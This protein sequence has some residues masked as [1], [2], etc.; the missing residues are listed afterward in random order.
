MADHEE[1]QESRLYYVIP[2]DVMI[3]ES[4]SASEKLLYALLSGLASGKGT[5]FPSNEYLEKR[6]K[7]SKATI[8]RWIQNLENAGYI[9]REIKTYADNPFKRTRIITLHVNFKKSLPRLKNEP[10]E[11]EPF[12]ELKSDL[13]E[14]SKMSPIVSKEIHLVSKEEKLKQKDGQIRKTAPQVGTPLYVKFGSFVK[15]KEKAYQE[16]CKCN[17][18]SCVDE[19]IQE[20]NGWLEATG[21]K[22]YKNYP[23]A[24]KNWIERQKKKRTYSSNNVNRGSI[25]DQR[26]LKDQNG[27]SLTDYSGKF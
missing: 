26:N 23:A 14:G 12:D 21:N 27:N 5:C 13:P 22:P 10:T 3:D 20:M 15:M 7:E 6:L 1:P 24:I 2:E 19:I 11:D 4:I 16:L 9:S 17:G 18:Q 25:T 8:K